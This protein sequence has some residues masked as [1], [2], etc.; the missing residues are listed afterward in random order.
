MRRIVG[1]VHENAARLGGVRDDTVHLGVCRRHDEPR[2]VEMA[3]LKV[4]GCHLDHVGARCQQQAA[5]GIGYGPVA[6]ENDA[7]P[8]EFQ[9]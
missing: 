6:D 5:F 2:I 7:A 9:K 1:G 8:G 3:R 4:C